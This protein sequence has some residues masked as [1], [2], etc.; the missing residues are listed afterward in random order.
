MVLSQRVT[1]ELDACVTQLQQLQ[2]Y[3]V[4]FQSYDVDSLISYARGVNE[5]CNLAK[6]DN[7]D[8]AEKLKSL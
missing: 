2:V 8:L 5:G 7:A 6:S 3:L 4:D 1:T